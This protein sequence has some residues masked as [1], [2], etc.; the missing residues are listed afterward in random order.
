MTFSLSPEVKI[1]INSQKRPKFTT[2]VKQRCF[3]LSDFDPEHTLNN[4][5]CFS[6]HAVISAIYYM[7]LVT[8]GAPA[9]F[10]IFR[11]DESCNQRW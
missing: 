8:S 1:A 5:E 3:I 11:Y 2:S 7:L 10:A 6:V 4:Q 9:L